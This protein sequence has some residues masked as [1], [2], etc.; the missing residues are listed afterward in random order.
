MLD[1]QL[2]AL[3]QRPLVTATSGAFLRHPQGS[4]WPI[5]DVARA[6]YRWLAVNVGDGFSWQAWQQV[7]DRARREGI[8]VMP[9]RRCFD[10]Q[11][12]RALMQLASDL[13]VQPIPN[14]EDE[15]ETTLA[16][17]RV[18]AICREYPVAVAGWSL[19]GWLYNDVD[20]RPLTYAP[21]LLQLFPF[22]MRF[23]PV[24]LPR[25]QRDCVWNARR[26]GF[27]HVGVTF[28]VYRG[29]K[30]EWYAYHRGTRSLYTGDDVGTGWQAWR[31]T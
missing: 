16:P 29:A 23:D 18:A 10:E 19:V 1:R 14:L 20:H 26:H 30:P 27:R 2:E 6:G 17:A 5:A 12:L 8:T 15:L 13:A 7:H 25:K 4:G 21:A 31:V 24:D 28:Q 22:D 11:Q 3:K 9:W